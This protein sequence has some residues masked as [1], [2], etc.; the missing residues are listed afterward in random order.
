VF[1]N[2]NLS[3]ET[4]L[5]SILLLSVL[6]ISIA[7]FLNKAKNDGLSFQLGI[8]FSV[9]FFLAPP[10]FFLIFSG[11]VEVDRF[12]FGGTDFKDIYINESAVSMLILSIYIILISLWTM[13]SENKIILNDVSDTYKSSKTYYLNTI[14]LTLIYSVFFSLII[15]IFSGISSG[16]GNWYESSAQFWEQ[17][18]FIGVILNFSHFAARLVFV[19]VFFFYFKNFINN[20]LL[21]FSFLIFFCLFDSY[22]TGNRIFLFVAL[23]LLGTDFLKNFGKRQ[24]YQIIIL[25]PLVVILGLASSVYGLLRYYISAFGIPTFDELILI[26]ENFEFDEWGLKSAILGMFESINFN[27]VMS[28]FNEATIHNIFYGESY[29]KVF[30]TFIPRSLW[31]DKPESIALEATKILS[32]SED[33]LS[34]A[35][36][37]IGE[38][39]FNFLYLGIL[40]IVPFLIVLNKICNACLGALPEIRSYF[41]FGIG[42]LMFRMSFSDTFMVFL[43]SILIMY[44]LRLR[45]N[46]KNN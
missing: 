5:S 12:G 7:I 37:M 33:H 36:T 28:I 42:V 10:S 19:T 20:K 45:I 4:Y 15:F 1:Y 31:P 11:T 39:H 22:I 38:M 16:G 2:S 43:I 41:L 30:F 29:L 24:A 18:G 27:V 9:L 32:P 35:L 13:F 40:F 3:F 25:T 44:F 14:Y 34:L 6:I 21:G 46:L 26:F 23:A 8:L 17:F